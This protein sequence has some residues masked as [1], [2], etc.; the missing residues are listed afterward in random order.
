MCGSLISDIGSLNKVEVA[1]WESWCDRIA[2]E[3]KELP[4]AELD[5]QLD[6]LAEMVTDERSFDE[7]QRAFREDE[8]LRPP[9]AAP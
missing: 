2:I 1:E 9:A 8:G 3:H 5:S 6:R 4:N 7:L